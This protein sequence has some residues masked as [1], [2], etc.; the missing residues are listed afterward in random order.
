MVNSE[1]DETRQHTFT[2]LCTGRWVGA[3]LVAV[4]TGSSSSSISSVWNHWQT[5]VHATADC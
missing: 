1:I 4:L 2:E 5:D 3:R